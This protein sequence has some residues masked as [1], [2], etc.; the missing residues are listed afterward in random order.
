[1]D[2]VSLLF[3]SI[4]GICAICAFFGALVYMVHLKDG[5]S[6]EEK[7]RKALEGARANLEFAVRQKAIDATHAQPMGS[8]ENV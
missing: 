2:P 5:E 3:F 7:K 6:R 8:V 1:M 4:I